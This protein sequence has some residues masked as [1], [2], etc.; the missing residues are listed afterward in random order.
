MKLGD[1][2]LVKAFPDED[3]HGT[4]LRWNVGRTAAPRP[5]S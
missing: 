2:G 1:E 3:E 5:Q 4:V